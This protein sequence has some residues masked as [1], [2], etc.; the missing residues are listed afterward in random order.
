MSSTQT[1]VSTETQQK[2]TE[3][4]PKDITKQFTNPNPG[5]TRRE[6][7]PKRV[8]AGKF[9]AERTR[10]VRELQKKAAAEA[11]VIIAN[12][13]AKQASPPPDPDPTPAKENSEKNSILST[14]QWLMVGSIVV[15]LLGIYYNREEL[16]VRAKALFDKKKNA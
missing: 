16:K 2:D 5:P 1:D 7:N 6:K 9:V 15:S 3:T 11:S 10:I 4:P 13:N 14:T 12:N 8:A